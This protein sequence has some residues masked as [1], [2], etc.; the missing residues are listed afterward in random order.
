M[1]I[2]KSASF[3]NPMGQLASE[4]YEAHQSAGNG[5]RDFSSILEKLKGA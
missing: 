2:A 1:E 3:D 4:L 5:Q